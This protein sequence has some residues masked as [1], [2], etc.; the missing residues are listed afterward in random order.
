MEGLIVVGTNSGGKE[1]KNFTANGFQEISAN[2][3][4]RF[5]GTVS[6]KTNVYCAKLFVV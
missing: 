3:S 5:I 2:S 6:S 1:R 4:D